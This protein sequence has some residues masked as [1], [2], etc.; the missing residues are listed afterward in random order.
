[1]SVKFN[2][3][4]TIHNKENILERTL[5]GVED[6]AGDNSVIYPVLDGCTDR[7]AEIVEQF[8]KRTKNKVII[9]ETADLHE[10]RSINAALRKITDGYT[11]CL[12]DDVILKEPNLESKV[13]NLYNKLG[14]DL[15]VISFCRAADIRKTPILRQI[16]RSGLV[17]LIE[18]CNLVQ[19]IND[20]CLGG[21][22]IP[23]EQFEYK[24]V[25][26]KSPVCI[27]ETLLKRIGLLDENLAPYGYDDHEYCMRALQFGFK[28]GLYPLHF[29]SELEWGGTRNDKDF[30]QKTKK[31]H[32]RNHR[33][34]WKKHGRFISNFWRDKGDA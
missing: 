12:Q 5:A 24:M 16:R 22:K 27:P 3:I 8:T 28:N 30:S 15:G 4:I 18:E 2:Y 1:M 21:I 20:S 13:I 6:C 10:I 23:Y 34:I 19:V 17:P 11:I 31:I 25:A 29:D 9:T 14:S 7:S 26:I 33:Y 32:L